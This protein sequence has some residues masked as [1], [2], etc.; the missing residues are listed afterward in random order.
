MTAAPRPE[1]GRL[2]VGAC[3]SLSGRHAR[4][5]RQARLGLELWRSWDETTELIVADDRSDP[6][7]VEDVL[8]SLATRCDVLL[9]PYS[10]HLMRRAGDVA[11]E[12]GLLVWNHG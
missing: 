11:A 8:R 3:L 9:G 6:G 1:T 4:F 5:G 2:R 7:T 10:T 12:L